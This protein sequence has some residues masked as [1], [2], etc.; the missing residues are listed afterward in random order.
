VNAKALSTYMGHGNISVTLDRYGHLMPGNEAQ[1]ADLLDAYLA[2]E[3]PSRDT[4]RAMSREN[5]EVVSAGIEAWNR[6]GVEGILRDFHPDFRGYPFPEW[7]GDPI[8][9]GIDGMRRLAL[10]WTDQFDDYRWDSERLIDLGDR[11]VAL[12][13]HHGRTKGDGIEI[14]QEMGVVF[15]DFRADGKVGEAHFFLTWAEALEAA[16]LSE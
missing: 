4:R 6:E 11:V 13:H 14:R 3:T 2:T 9:H 7:I 15:G 12:V 5:V 1:T 8:Y 16:G 10:E